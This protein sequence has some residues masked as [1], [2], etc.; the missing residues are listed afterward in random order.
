MGD[1]PVSRIA[2]FLGT[3]TPFNIMK[4]EDVEEMA[5]SMEIAYFPRGETV[6]RTG[7]RVPDHVHVI[8]TGSITV[9]AS[10]GQGGEILVDVRGEGDVFGA[11]SILTVKNALFDVKVNEDLVSYLLPA[12]VLIGVVR[13]YPEIEQYFINSLAGNVK[14]A[15]QTMVPRQHHGIPGDIVNLEVYLIGKTI[16]DIMVRDVLTCS[17][18]TSIRDAVKLMTG[19]RVSSIVVTN[20]A[21]NP[22]GILTDTDLRQKVLARGCS[23]DEQVLHVMT[24]PVHSLRPDAY[25]FDAL[26][27]MSRH[28]ISHL[29]VVE[30]ERLRGIVS[31]HD[32]QVQTGNSPVGVIGEIEKCRSVED[33]VSLRPKID[34][35]LEMLVRQRVPARKATKLITEFNDRVTSKINRLIEEEME[36]SGFGPP[37]VSFC[38]MALGSEGRG[39]QTLRTDQDNAIIFENV[40]ESEDTSVKNW[41]GEYSQRVVDGLARYG[42]PRCRGGIMASNPQWCLSEEQWQ[43]V[44][45]GWVTRP[46][47]LSL[48]MA[49]I[50]FDL[51]PIC[52][53]K[54]MTERL[55]KAIHDLVAHNTLFLRYMAKNS[56]SNRPPLGF[57][58]QFIVEKTG[59]HRDELDLKMRAVLPVV[60]SSRV[61]ALELCVAGTNTVER[62]KEINRKDRSVVSD[63]LL[64]DLVEAYDFITHLRLTNHIEAQ[65]RGEAP[66]NFLNPG[67]LAG[68][69]RSLLKE[70]FSVISRLQE[71][72]GQ[73]Y[74][75]DLLLEV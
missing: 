43:A 33:T 12:D 13:R 64:S 48:R 49:S 6:M 68:I 10:D 63:G 15:R 51:R 23:V 61:M 47:A 11:L 32:F 7:D 25:A 42:F 29:A 3:V 60:E 45:S 5:R 70:S 57:L 27:E 54:A 73:R 62:L 67:R 21:G 37:P 17:V 20:G 71:Q 65:V 24:S 53:N 18:G 46:E 72:V 4:R 2:D 69:Q 14:A 26:L 74:R 16:S 19:R 8:Q 28:G 1:F 41:F 50:F 36:V 34:H 30:E 59:E 44:F 58:R 39:E 55:W 52:G 31:E 75:T 40:Q 35:I 22:V 38:W 56:L 9:T 66:G